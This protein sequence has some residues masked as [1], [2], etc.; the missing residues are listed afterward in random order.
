LFATMKRLSFRLVHLHKKSRQTHS[1]PWAKATAI[2]P[3]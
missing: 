1:Y 3:N 2:D